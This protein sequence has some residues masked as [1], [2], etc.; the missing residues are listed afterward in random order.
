MESYGD[1]A[2]REEWTEQ[3]FLGGPRIGLSARLKMAV[4]RQREKSRRLRR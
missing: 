4:Y 2:V 1:F 3:R